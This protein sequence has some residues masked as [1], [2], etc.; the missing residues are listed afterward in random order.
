MI[1]QARAEL[2]N[3][4]CGLLA[5]RIVDQAEINPSRGDVLVQTFNESRD[6]LLNTLLP[7]LDNE[8]ETKDVAQETF[9]ECWRRRTSLPEIVNMRAWILRIGLNIAVDR[10]RNAWRRQPR[11]PPT[12]YALVVSRYPLVNEAASPTEYLSEPYSMFAA[13]KNR[14]T[15]E[16]EF[17]A[18]YHSHPT[19]DP[20]PSRTD[21]ERN[22]SPDVMNL[23]VSL[24]NDEPVVRAWWL[25]ADSHREAEWL[26][27]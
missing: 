6:E 9:L 13:E 11:R 19:S 8:E 4:C 2:P 22:Y 17:L 25:T 23:I 16:L 20:V 15:D 5:G 1:A 10:K 7:L 26:V 27:T 24:K 21:R 12:R 18:I 3:E 14:R